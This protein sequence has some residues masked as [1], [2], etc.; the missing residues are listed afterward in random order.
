MQDIYTA[1]GRKKNEKN[2]QNCSTYVKLCTKELIQTANNISYSNQLAIDQ[3]MKC[4]NDFIAL[5]PVG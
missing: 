4:Q 2:Q 5:P 3:W 1:D